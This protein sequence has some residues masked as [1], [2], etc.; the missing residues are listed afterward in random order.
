[1]LRKIT[2]D[3]IADIKTKELR[4][5]AIMYQNIHDGFIENV[6][7]NDIIF[8]RNKDINKETKEIIA[9]L[10]EKG[11]TIRNGGASIYLNRIST[12]CIACKKGI[13]SIT[14]YISLMCHRNCY[15]CFNPNQEDF[16]CHLH[17]K[18]DWRSELN[19]IIKLGKELTHIAL[20]GG[21]PL[22]HA[23]EVL[24]FYRFAKEKFPNAHT[25]LYTS[26]DLL[27]EDY[28]KE[29]QNI[30]LN[31]IRFSIKMEDSKEVRDNILDIISLSKQYIN[32]VMVEMPVIPGTEEEMKKLLKRLNQIGI[33][34]INLLEFC[35][36]YVNIEEFQK[37]DF[38]LKYP[39]YKTLYNF[40]YAGGLPISE[41]ELLCLKL[42]EF[43]VDEKLEIG[44]HYCSLENKHF[45]Q[46]YNQNTSVINRDKSLVLSDTDYYLKTI[47]IFGEDSLKVK[48]ILE[49]NRIND[50][51]YNEEYKFI[52][53]NPKY[54]EML[55]KEKIELAVSYNIMET[56]EDGI[57]SRELKVEYTTTDKFELKYL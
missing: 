56:R 5:Y 8:C 43:S 10:K 13:G 48:K 29:L 11:A 7:G 33:F 53:F 19:Q 15:Y 40:W 12:A 51:V 37:R 52:Q 39:P 6:E 36:P 23:D 26:G 2:K 27:N 45:G 44:V 16:Q 50:Y 49:N 14:S 57:Y 25:R 9:R 22:L 3:N 21:E 1:M 34:G 47:K 28:L 38:K 32:D 17:A 35:F 46:V 42:M 30:G 18:K 24:E 54:V 55:N 4:E 41:S 20:T 31:E